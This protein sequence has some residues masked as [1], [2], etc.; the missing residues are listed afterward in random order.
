MEDDAVNS[1]HPIFFPV[2][3]YGEAEVTFFLD[4][5]KIAKS[6]LNFFPSRSLPQTLKFRMEYWSGDKPDA[7][8]LDSV[9]LDVTLTGIGVVSRCVY[10]DMTEWRLDENSVRQTV[11]WLSKENKPMANQ[12]ISRI[13][14]FDMGAESGYKIVANERLQIRLSGSES[15]STLSPCTIVSPGDAIKMFPQNLELPQYASRNPTDTTSGFKQ[16]HVGIWIEFYNGMNG[17]VYGPTPKDQ[18]YEFS[19]GASPAETGD[20]GAWSPL[21]KFG[22]KMGVVEAL[23]YITGYNLPVTGI[24]AAHTDS[25]HLS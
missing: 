9:S 10:S 17:A 25:A 21:V 13:K 7:K 22:V 15:F 14:D 3:N 18:V 1:N 12:D 24:S 2:N 8:L 5:N 23:K 6:E 19:I 20:F 4:F 16:G 11:D